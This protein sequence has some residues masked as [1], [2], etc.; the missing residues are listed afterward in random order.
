M[1]GQLQDKFLNIFKT[2]RGHGKI[3]DK[4]ISDAVREIRIA[5]LES[6]VNFK[7]VSSFVSKVKDKA[8]GSKVL[9][10]ITP[11]QQFVKIVLDEMISFLNSKESKINFNSTKLS[12]IVLVG[13]QGTGKTTTLA[14]IACFLKREFKKNPILI[15]ADCQRPAAK[16][17]LR[18]LS[19]NNNIDFYS[20]DSKKPLNVIK[21]G[22]D[23]AKKN[24]N[25]LI[26][27]D[28]AGR[29]HIDENLIDELVDV[30][31]YV[32]PDEVLYVLDSMSGQDAVNSSEV[33]ADK[34]NLTGGIITKLDGGSGAG[35]TL[36]FKETTGLPIKF[37]TSGEN[38]NSI[39][40]F[41]PESIS[42]RI[43]GLGDIVGLVEKA[44]SSFDE[45]NTLKL[46][47]QI[48]KNKFD[49]EDFLSQINQLNKIGSIKDLVKYMPGGNKIK[50][51]N[52]NDKQLIWTK[53]IIQ[54]MTAEERKKPEILN[55]SRRSRIAKGSG[56]NI[57]E[58]NRLIKQFNQM[59]L[60]MKKMNKINMGKFPF[61]LR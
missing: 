1:F 24:K 21:S 46:Q 6:D 35:A 55:G 32:N 44:Q 20:N 15:G 23:F 34:I 33:F 41:N 28:T 49:F 17:Q 13:L 37:M 52:F 5:L 36:S 25:D 9:D 48:K 8:S 16:E 47:E 57:N 30:I 40:L 61:K 14:K 58:V 60:M 26:L 2:V 7:V 45:K 59:K 39:E 50:N 22:I 18:V 42:R 53:A 19:K 54:S 43:L 3:S 56:R 10:S 29:L 4:N 12:K 38:I 11:G 51:L 27:I 31:N